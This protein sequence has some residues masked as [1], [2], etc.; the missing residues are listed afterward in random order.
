MLVTAQNHCKS[1]FF[2]KGGDGAVDDF[3]EFLL[4]QIVVGAGTDTLVFSSA[5]RFVF[6][7]FERV[8]LA[9][10]LLP[11]GV[12]HEV[13]RDSEKEG[14][15]FGGGLVSLGGLPEPDEDLLGDILCVWGLVSHLGDGA[16]HGLLVLFDKA[17]E[18]RFIAASDQRH[19]GNVLF[20]RILSHW[21][22]NLTQFDE[23]SRAKIL[24]FFGLDEVLV[25][26]ALASNNRLV[27]IDE[28]FRWKRVGIVG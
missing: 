14:G 21:L 2:R 19:Q 3:S 18:G 16:K 1:L 20:V 12:E 26:L 25:G 24:S 7:L 27:A 17:S 23:G 28:D 6:L 4:G 15:E 5:V 13:A 10:G 8:F 22:V 11:G 9:T